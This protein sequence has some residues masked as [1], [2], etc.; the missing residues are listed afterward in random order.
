MVAPPRKVAPAKRATKAAK[1][2][3]GNDD[4]TAWQDRQPAVAVFREPGDTESA[5]YFPSGDETDV[6]PP[7][8]KD[9]IPPK[10]PSPTAVKVRSLV[11]RVRSSA[12]P[13]P[14][15]RTPKA[16][17][18]VDKLIGGLWQVAAQLTAPINLPV[19]R[20]LDMQAPVAG[21]LLED[22]V[23]DTVVDRILQPIARF[24]SGG[25]TA[26]ALMGPPLLVGLLTSKPQ[27]APILVPVLRQ[28]L[29]SWIEIAGP[30][31]EA[32]TKKEEKFHEQYGQRIDDMIAYF[33]GVTDG[34]SATTTATNHHADS[35]PTG[36]ATVS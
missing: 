26:F 24:E 27:L 10:I 17:V 25:E 8:P 2:V 35:A 21:M 19:A 14:K 16:R 9:E 12:K 31:L 32:V 5:D 3:A 30:K 33:I 7:A 36:T 1:P 15:S 20:V 13:K 6:T 4:I 11:D 28:S 18:S 29:M 34:P 22:V 23:K